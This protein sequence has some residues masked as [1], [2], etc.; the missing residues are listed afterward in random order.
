M[1]DHLEVGEKSDIRDNQRESG[2]LHFLPLALLPHCVS[3]ALTRHCV[4]SS[5][6]F[7]SRQEFDLKTLQAD[8]LE[9]PGHW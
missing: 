5:C 7:G 3:I 2:L 1:L 8:L 9:T 4:R 6:C